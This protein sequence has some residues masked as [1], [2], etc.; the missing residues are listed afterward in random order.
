MF[1]VIGETNDQGCTWTVVTRVTHIPFMLAF[2]A[3]L[4]KGS[5]YWRHGNTPIPGHNKYNSQGYND[6]TIQNFM[7]WDSSDLIQKIAKDQ[8]LAIYALKFK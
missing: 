8:D 4:K 5:S 2:L 6:P 7:W 1:V 3:N